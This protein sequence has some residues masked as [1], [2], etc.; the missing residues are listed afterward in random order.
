MEK[1]ADWAQAAGGIKKPRRFRPGTVALGEI[2]RYLKST[3]PL[4][5]KRPFRRLVREIARDF[6]TA[7]CFQ[8]GAIAALQEASEAYLVGLFEG[9][10]LC[11]S[12]GTVV[13]LLDL[14][15]SNRD[16][17]VTALD[18]ARQEEELEKTKQ[19]QP[20]AKRNELNVT[21]VEPWFVV[22]QKADLETEL[23]A[24]GGGGGGAVKRSRLLESDEDEDDE[25]ELMQIVTAKR[26]KL[27]GGTDVSDYWK[28]KQ[29]YLNF[30]KRLSLSWEPADVDERD[31]DEP[32]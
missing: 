29:D 23:D 4:I 18:L 3:E 7:L 19:E 26:A 30:I 2:R 13:S 5:R 21:D 20:R 6:K 16:T 17:L 10:N 15:E 1:H 25:E 11:A 8:A 28:P 27:Q 12:H 31:E 24:R 32:M 14:R 22:S 9:A